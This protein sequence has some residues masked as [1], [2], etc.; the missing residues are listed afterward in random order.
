[1]PETRAKILTPLRTLGNSC[2]SRIE[3]CPEAGFTSFPFTW[4]KTWSET[5]AFFLRN[6]PQQTTTLSFLPSSILVNAPVVVSPLAHRSP[7][8]LDEVFVFVSVVALAPAINLFFFGFFEL[9][10]EGI[11]F[12]DGCERLQD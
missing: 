12:L 4:S 10:D 2:F 3:Q 9:V 11:N 7:A 1:M 6:L 8:I 5:F